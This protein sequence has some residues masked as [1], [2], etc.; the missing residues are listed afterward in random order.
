MLAGDVA[1]QVPAIACEIDVSWEVDVPD[2]A[3][4]VPVLRNWVS[5]V[6]ASQGE[7]L[8]DE[9]VPPGGVEISLLF[10]DNLTI[11]QL[12]R[13]Y[14]QQDKAT[15]VLS[16]PLRSQVEEQR[17]L[18]GDLVICPAVVV[19]EAQIQGKPFAVHLTHLVIHGVLH[20]L[21]YDHVE[22]DQAVLMESIEIN[23]MASLGHQNPY[24]SES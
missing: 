10:T 6:I 15:N 13:D 2:W 4:S 20:L 1:S 14:R 17:L 5:R 9:I 3:P 23:L 11:Q 12:N 18:L 19:A 16:F 24:V 7:A 21:G 8:Q 22:D